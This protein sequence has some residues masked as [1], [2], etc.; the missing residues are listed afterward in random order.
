MRGLDA[1]QR[2]DVPDRTTHIDSIR[3]NHRESGV[4]RPRPRLRPPR[5]EAGGRVMHRSVGRPEPPRLDAL[6]LERSRA[7]G[8]PISSTGQ[9][10][11]RATAHLSG[12]VYVGASVRGPTGD[13][14]RTDAR[15]RVCCRLAGSAGRIEERASYGEMEGRARAGGIGGG[16]EG[17][18]APGSPVNGTPPNA[19][20]F[21]NPIA[22]AARRRREDGTDSLR[23]GGPP[24]AARRSSRGDA[25]GALA[26]EN[27]ALQV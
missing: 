4:A 9:A 17:I 24:L 13:G 22:A 27:V 5:T 15:D 10:Q 18:A 25:T 21:L 26:R 16:A 23:T 3:Y 8:R 20:G 14:R 11:S 12:W 6:H 2:C 19:F 7:A 1:K